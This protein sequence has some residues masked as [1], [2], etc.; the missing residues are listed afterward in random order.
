[1]TVAGYN[2]IYNAD[3]G[4][5][6]TCNGV[7]GTYRQ[8]GY[9]WSVQAIKVSTAGPLPNAQIGYGDI[10][11]NPSF[12]DNT[13][14]FQTWGQKSANVNGDGTLP[15]VV[16]TMQWIFSHTPSTQ[17]PAMLTWIRNGYRPKASALKTTGWTLGAGNDTTSTDANGN[18]WPGA[19]AT[20]GAMAYQSSASAAPV[21]AV[22]AARAS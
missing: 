11:N 13:R 1:V 18:S 21:I 17:I 3:A 20:F 12:V 5:Y 7:T 4:S 8:T 22:L 19:T 10:T 14:E 15:T 9:N 16:A 6:I 2:C